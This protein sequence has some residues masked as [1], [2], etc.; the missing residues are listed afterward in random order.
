MGDEEGGGGLVEDGGGHAL[1]KE[2]GD[3]CP[4]VGAHDDEG[5]TGV[6]PDDLG[7]DFYGLARRGLDLE[8][9]EM[10]GP[11]GLEVFVVFELVVACFH[12]YEVSRHGAP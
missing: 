7:E 3:G 4:A 5:V 12:G 10:P 2:A 9:I 1:A 6:V 8:L 11:P